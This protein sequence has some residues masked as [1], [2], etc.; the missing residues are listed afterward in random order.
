MIRWQTAHTRDCATAS[1]GQMR[2]FAETTPTVTRRIAINLAPTSLAT[3]PKLPLH[4]CAQPAIATRHPDWAN[5][6]TEARPNCNFQCQINVLSGAPSLGGETHPL[7]G[8]G[9][10]PQAG[11][12]TPTPRGFTRGRTSLAR[13]PPFLPVRPRRATMASSAKNQTVVVLTT[14]FPRSGDHHGSRDSARAGA[15]CKRACSPAAVPAASSGHAVRP[16]AGPWHH[17][18]MGP[19]HPRR[20][21]HFRH[22]DFPAEPVRGRWHALPPVP[23]LAD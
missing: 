7:R 11:S 20:G 13:G 14:V 23:W 9:R 12:P 18:R 17:N 10:T 6:S 2:R 22:H 4:D 3:L 19:A 8:W 5:A 1:C 16:C 21:D 15:A